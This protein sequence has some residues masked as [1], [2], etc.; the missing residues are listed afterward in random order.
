MYDKISET[1][2]IIKSILSSP[3]AADRKKQRISLLDRKKKD[4]FDDK[5]DAIKNLKLKLS[6]NSQEKCTLNLNYCIFCLSKLLKNDH[7]NYQLLW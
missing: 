4:N 3:S 5:Y 7:L 2:F 1:C 6:H